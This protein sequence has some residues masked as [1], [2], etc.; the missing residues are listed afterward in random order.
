MTEYKLREK[1]V[2]VEFDPLTPGKHWGVSIYLLDDNEDGINIR[3][4]DAEFVARDRVNGKTYL[5]LSIGDGITVTESEGLFAIL[6]TPSHTTG[7]DV[8]RLIYDF[9]V[10]DD[11]GVQETYLTGVI[12][13]HQ[14]V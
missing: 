14:K 10:T 8:S 13:V 7:V 9:S 1:P 6:A 12:P 11:D 2:T 5:S 4:Y 3:D